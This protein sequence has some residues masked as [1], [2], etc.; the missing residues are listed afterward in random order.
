MSKISHKILTMYSDEELQTITKNT[1]LWHCFI[2]KTQK[3][4]PH[5]YKWWDEFLQIM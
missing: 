2:E 1:F 5:F 4:N 3:E